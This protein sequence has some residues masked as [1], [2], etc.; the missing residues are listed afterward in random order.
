MRR[1]TLLEPARVPPLTAPILRCIGNTERR[2]IAGHPL[3]SAKHGGGELGRHTRSHTA[4]TG[5]GGGTILG[6]TN[7]VDDTTSSS[8]KTKRRTDTDTT[9]LIVKLL[10]AALTAITIP[11]V[12][13]TAGAAFIAVERRRVR[14]RWWVGWSILSLIIGVITAGGVLGW[15]VSPLHLLGWLLAAVLHLPIADAAAAVPGTFGNR[16]AAAADASLSSAILGQ[17]EF[18]VP[19][20]SMITVVYARVRRFRRAKMGE[21]EGPEYANHR[22]VGVLDHLRRR[23]TTR[24]IQRGAFT[25]PPAGK[26]L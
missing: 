21:I 26:A 4:L 22:P 14:I 19:V 6:S 5:K 2:L 24:L 16:L 3:I 17:I 8:G 25:H 18:G 1:S 12:V 10:V 11:G 15:L 13:V 7:P 23:I 9:P 20:A